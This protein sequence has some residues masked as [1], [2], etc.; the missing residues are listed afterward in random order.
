MAVTSDF[1][2]FPDELLVALSLLR[3]GFNTQVARLFRECLSTAGTAGSPP[4]PERLLDGIRAGLRADRQAWSTDFRRARERARQAL[5]QAATLELETI[6]WA[7]PRYPQ[8]LREIPDP[9]IAFWTRGAAEL[10]SRATVAVVGARGASPTGLAVA[11]RL[12]GE[13]ADAGLAVV[14]GLARGVDGAAH[15]GALS[16][17]GI[18]IAVLGNGLDRAYPAEHRQLFAEI[19]GAGVLVSEFPPG[20]LPLPAHFPLRN[21]IIS[22]LS[23]AVVLV[24]ASERSGSLITARAALEQG[25]EVMAVPGNVASGGS[26]GCHAL[27][28]DGARLV[29][30]V[31]DILDEL[32]WTPPAALVQVP[33]DNRLS[34][35]GLAQ[36][37]PSGEPVSVDEL[38]VR[39]GRPAAECLA[40]LTLLEMASEVARTAGGTFVRVDG[41]AT[42]IGTRPSRDGHGKGAGTIHAESAGRRRIA[43]KGED[44]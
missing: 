41:P 29:E 6:T 13:L 35:S 8:L 36:F 39:S 43:R 28:K 22:G 2:G 23:R 7:S 30:T 21:R 12:S 44:D 11:R 20:A 38:S 33:A 42:N 32:G 24:E 1:S 25:R 16:A 40:A 34:S 14:S 15:R 31:G 18:T 3:L 9:P 37:L 17:G 19:A 5:E 26:R 4:S 27:I 10:L